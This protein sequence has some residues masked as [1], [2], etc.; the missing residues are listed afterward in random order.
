MTEEKELTNV[1][2]EL[3]KRIEQLK[4]NIKNSMM[5]GEVNILKG[6]VIFEVIL[7]EINPSVIDENEALLIEDYVNKYLIKKEDAMQRVNSYIRY[8]INR[9]FLV[10]E[11]YNKIKK[12]G[13]K[14]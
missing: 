11:S 10:L 3:L 2:K 9:C 13:L 4:K 12:H 5:S 14:K 8:G 1:T 6:I 7:K